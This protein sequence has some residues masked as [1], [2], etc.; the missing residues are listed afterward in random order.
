MPS[1]GKLKSLNM[2]NIN[3]SKINGG[4]EHLQACKNLQWILIGGV[5]ITDEDAT[6]ISKYPSLSH[7]TM[8]GDTDISDSALKIL[9]SV[10]DCNVDSTAT[11]TSVSSVKVE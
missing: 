10:E 6:N 4:Y 1:V 2:F 7:V 3:G 5:K 8:D 11:L 9:K